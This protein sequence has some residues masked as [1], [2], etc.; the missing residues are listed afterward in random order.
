MKRDKFLTEWSLAIRERD[1][2]CQVCGK[3]PDQGRLNAH[4]IIPKNFL[5]YKYDLSNGMTLCVTCHQFGK[6]SAHKN[7]LWFANWFREQRPY[8]FLTAS[9]RIRELLDEI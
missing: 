8:D 7:P 5:K 3:T 2:A 1:G 9:Q 6:F 4:H